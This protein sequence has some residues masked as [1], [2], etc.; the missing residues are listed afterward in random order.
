M[1]QMLTLNHPVY[2]VTLRDENN[3]QVTEIPDG[4]FEERRTLAP[5]E[6]IILLL[7]NKPK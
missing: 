1:K 5:G 6:K 7:V 4:R 2:P 3:G